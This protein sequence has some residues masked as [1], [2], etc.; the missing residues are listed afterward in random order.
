M[1]Q[2]GPAGTAGFGDE[3]QLSD[4]FSVTCIPSAATNTIVLRAADPRGCHLA[5]PGGPPGPQH[6]SHSPNPAAGPMK[7]P[8]AGPLSTPACV[9]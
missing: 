5:R 3:S 2:W 1:V 6:G 4:G 7:P 8:I 9:K